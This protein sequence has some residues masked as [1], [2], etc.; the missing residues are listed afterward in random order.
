MKTVKM[1][2]KRFRRLICKFNIG[3]VTVIYDWMRVN[4]D[5]NHIN[6]LGVENDHE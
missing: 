2:L 5:S 1:R 3:P 4:R 6:R